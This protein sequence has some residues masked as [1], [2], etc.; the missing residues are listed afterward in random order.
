VFYFK[1]HHVVELLLGVFA[2]EELKRFVD[3]LNNSC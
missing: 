3:V 2:D 1:L